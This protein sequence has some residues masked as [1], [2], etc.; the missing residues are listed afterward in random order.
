[1]QAHFSGNKKQSGGIRHEQQA[2][3]HEVDRLILNWIT[4]ELDGVLTDTVI[5]SLLA[6]IKL[7]AQE[8]AHAHLVNVNKGME[9]ATFLAQELRFHVQVP[10]LHMEPVDLNELC[11]GCRE[12]WRAWAPAQ[13]QVQL[14]LSPQMA[15]VWGDRYRLRQVLLN[16]L[17]NATDAV[18]RA[19][20]GGE[21]R[22]TLTVVSQPL[23]LKQDEAPAFANN[24]HLPPGEYACLAVTDRGPGMDRETLAHLFEPA[25]GS[26]SRPRKCGLTLCLQI[27]RE[28]RGGIQVRSRPEQGSTFQF[29]LPAYPLEKTTDAGQHPRERPLA[30]IID[31]DPD[32]RHSVANLLELIGVETRSAANGLEGLGLLEAERERFGLVL[33]DLDLPGMDGL[34]TY[35]RLR[36]IAPEVKVIFTSANGHRFPVNEQI[37]FLAKPYD[38]DTL[39]R[40][41]QTALAA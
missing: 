36:R 21:G 35:W 20:Y 30:L 26:R 10:P 2:R 15:P 29:C 41:V 3:Q 38:A 23:L 1:M 33:L 19:G 17:V 14:D 8:P 11:R 39:L 27:I 34:D 25:F 5:Q 4:H 18:A 6:L 37:F 32:I 40:Q 12:L 16:F 31:D 24:V 22:N 7:P 9:C 28:H 13:V